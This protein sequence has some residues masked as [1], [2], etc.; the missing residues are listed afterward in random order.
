[1]K[2][3]ARIC[4]LF[5][6]A[7]APVKLKAQTAA[8]TPVNFAV[9]ADYEGNHPLNDGS[10]WRLQTDAMIRRSKGV[11]IARSYRFKGGIGYKFN[12]GPRVAGGYTIEY[13]YP[14]DAASEPYKWASQ[15]IWEEANLRTAIGNGNKILTQR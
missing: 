13:N 1:M 6:L 4:V 10:P 7:K 2:R 15:R 11:A 8:E 12:R 14:Y 5:L 9:W 3:I